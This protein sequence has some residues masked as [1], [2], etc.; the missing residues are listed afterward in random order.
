MRRPVIITTLAAALVA[1]IVA[2]VACTDDRDRGDA[3]RGRVTQLPE[4]GDAIGEH[5]MLAL[6]Q[7]KNFHHKAKVYMADGKLDDATTAVRQILA[8]EF[9]AGAPEGEDV[10]LDAHALLAKLHLAQGQLEPAMTTVDRGIA[11][12]TRDSFFLANLHTVRGEIFEAIAADFASDPSDQARDRAKQAWQSAID[13]YDASIQINEQL[14]RA[15]FDR[16]RQGGAP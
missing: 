12:A 16:M 8:I 10:R 6:A 3:P 2:T 9:P 11:A 1:A 4:P 13:A 5:L 14:Q 7:A 15:L